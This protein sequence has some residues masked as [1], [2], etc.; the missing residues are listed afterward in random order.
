MTMEFAQ[1]IKLNPKLVKIRSYKY[2]WGSCNS[3]GVITYN[4]KLIMAPESIIKY[5]VVHELCHRKHFNHSNDFWNEVS[6]YIPDY[7]NKKEW[8][9]QNT[10]VFEW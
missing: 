2:R 10:N 7:K 9:N 1:E 8:L 6:K 4:W 5:V 3:K